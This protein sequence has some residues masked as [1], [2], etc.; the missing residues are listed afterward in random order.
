MRAPRFEARASAR[1]DPR[2]VV[3]LINEETVV[4]RLNDAPVRAE[5]ASAPFAYP[6]GWLASEGQSRGAPRNVV[7]PTS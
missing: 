6:A 7:S 5:G 4:S 2:S 3:T 1:R